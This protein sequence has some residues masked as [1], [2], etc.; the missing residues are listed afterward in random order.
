MGSWQGGGLV[1]CLFGMAIV[2]MLSIASRAEREPHRPRGGATQRSFFTTPRTVFVV[3][4]L[5]IV[6]AASWAIE[7]SYGGLLSDQSGW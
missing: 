7:S 5:S 1:A 4:W 6:G 3:V 2:G